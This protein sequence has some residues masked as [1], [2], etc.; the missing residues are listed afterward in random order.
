M[1][2]GVCFLV[3]DHSRSCVVY[4]FGRVCLSVQRRRQVA[5]AGGTNGGKGAHGERGS[6]KGKES[7]RDTCR[8]SLKRIFMVGLTRVLGAYSGLRRLC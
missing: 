1:F 5:S 4:N 3:F 6:A 8:F 7:G 2:S